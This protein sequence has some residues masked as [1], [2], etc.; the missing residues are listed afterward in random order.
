MPKNELPSV[1]QVRNQTFDWGDRTY[2]MGVL[3]VTPD[4]F[5]DGGLFHAPEAAIVQARTLIAAGV[6]ILDVGGQSTRPNAIEISLD[7]ELER[8]LPIIQAVRQESD[9]PLSIDTT[10]ASVAQAAIAAGADLVN[11]ISGAT[12]DAEM[13]P[14]VAK[15]GV[16]IVLMHIRG[17]PQTMQ[18]LTDY[19]DLISDILTFLK[20]RI[21]AAIACGIDRSRIAIDPGIG[22]AKTY[23]QNLEILRRLPE[24]HALGYPLL[25][26]A[27]RKSFIGHI[28]NQP[29]PQQRVW[30]TAAA[31]CAAIAG[32]AD[33]LRVHDV[34]EMKDVCRVADALFR[35][36]VLHTKL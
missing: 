24:F 1:W 19:E 32:K 20:A 27:S 7:E 10:R 5:S 4:S 8:V 34:K 23:A 18:Q 36:Y 2:L 16:P 15:L 30:G 25:V 14:V 22:F 12:Y 33:L 21:D 31:C 3:N 17:M 35:S 9:V 26:G 29:D 28:L 13:L 6:D 11:D